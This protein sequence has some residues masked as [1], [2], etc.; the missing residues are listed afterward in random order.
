MKLTARLPKAFFIP[1]VSS[2]IS[3]GEYI[4]VWKVCKANPEKEYKQTITMWSG[5]TG[6]DVLREIMDGIH[7]RI[8]QRPLINTLQK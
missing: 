8:N 2:Y 1:S 7:D 5:G 3:T 6:A 4:K